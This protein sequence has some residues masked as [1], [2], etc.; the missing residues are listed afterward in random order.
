MRS[1]TLKERLPMWK[2]TSSVCSA[3]FEGCS[4]IPT[5]LSLCM[6]SSS[7]S[8]TCRSGV[9]CV[10][11][12]CVA[13]WFCGAVW[14]C[15]AVWFCVD[16]WCC[17][18]VWFCGG[19]FWELEGSNLISSIEIALTT[20]L[21]GSTTIPFS[22]P[23]KTASFLMAADSYF[24]LSIACVCS[25]TISCSLVLSFCKPHAVISLASLFLW[26]CSSIELQARGS[27]FSI[28]WPILEW[29]I[30]Q[31]KC[32]KKLQQIS[33]VLLGTMAVLKASFLLNG[34]LVMAK[35]SIHNDSVKQTVTNPSA[36]V[37]E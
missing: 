32:E 16:V 11:D 33:Q 29:A 6:F 8:W 20:W 37:F 36:S 5:G 28:F 31:E 2:L 19:W 3:G 14:L 18:A 25:F 35:F 9:S 26:S 22:D 15:D 12:G 34:D 7:T 27:I 23:I 17:V 30:L 10:W 4:V 21:I 1:G 24:R 13:V